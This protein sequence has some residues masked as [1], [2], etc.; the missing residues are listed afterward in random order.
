[1]D[2]IIESK[3]K[4]KKGVVITVTLASGLTTA[5][6]A[7]TLQVNSTLASGHYL[8]GI[9][10]ADDG[11][12]LSVGLDWS[13]DNG[14]FLGTEC[15]VGGAE[16]FSSFEQGC[17]SYAGYFRP[18][19]ANNALSFEAKRYD[20]NGRDPI[21]WDTSEYSINWH[22]K[23]ALL[24]SATLSDDWLA[25]GT[26]TT[27]LD[28][29]Y[30]YALNNSFSVLTQAGVLVPS[31]RQTFDTLTTGSIGLQYQHNRWSTV[32]KANFVDSASRQNLPF[33]IDDPEFF[34]SISYQLY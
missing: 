33:D 34:W 24:V 19:N 27:A 30:T 8:R 3:N 22:Y 4:I 28:V 17:V 20:Y 26:S 10:L 2:R 29:S 23:E 25:R 16:R 14:L 7:G 32:I 15:F 5:V 11:P 13:S 6:S 12:A 18:L 31:T 21:D 9:E 1:M